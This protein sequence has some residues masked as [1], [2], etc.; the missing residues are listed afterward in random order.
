[1]T[2]LGVDIGGT[3]IKGIV[4]QDGEFSDIISLP[5]HASHGAKVVMESVYQTVETLLQKTSQNINGIGIGVP[6]LVDESGVLDGDPVNIRT[7]ASMDIRHLVES[8]FK[9]KTVMAND[10]NLAA[11]AESQLGAGRGFSPVVCY[12][13]GTGVGGGIVIGG[14]LYTG[15]NGKAAELGHIVVKPGGRKC[16]CKLRGCVEEYASIRGI[17]N[18]CLALAEDFDSKL[19]AVVAKGEV[20]ITPKLIYRYFADNDPLA[21]AVNDFTCK[22]LAR[23]I[24]AVFTTLTPQVIVL[25]GGISN[26]AEAM[27]PVIM[28]NLPKNIYPEVLSGGVKIKRAQLGDRAGVIGAALFGQKCKTL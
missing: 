10:V 19:S 14:K 25:G 9:I 23:A 24:G 2:F 1:M 12:A 4:S 13:L 26:S 16:T 3:T 5:T 22:M 7:L 11:F 18:N 27:I 21:I 8:R 20:K 15:P 6:G 28:K 17:I